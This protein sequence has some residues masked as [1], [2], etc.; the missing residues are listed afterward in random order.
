MRKLFFMLLLSTMLFSATANAYD[1][2]D[3]Y[4]EEEIEWTVELVPD[5]PI[6]PGRPKAPV[7][8]PKVCKAGSVL[9]FQNAHPA[10]ILYII[11][12]GIV[13]YCTIVSPTT[14]TVQLPETLSGSCV[15]QLVMGNYL[16]T[17]TIIL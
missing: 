14:T 3:D 7:S 11:K 1:N 13:E 4:D 17:G 8:F 15:V 2:N 6:R 16:F 5:E 12:E 9:I 10:Y